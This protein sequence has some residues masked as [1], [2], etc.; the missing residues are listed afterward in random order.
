MVVLPL[1]AL[2]VVAAVAVGAARLAYRP[3]PTEL[4]AAAP[5]VRPAEGSVPAS[6]PE[7]VP[8][9]V[10][11]A[12][13]NGELPAVPVPAGWQTFEYD[14]LRLSVP[15]AW[16]V[17]RHS[18]PDEQGC[19]DPTT[20][21][22]DLNW[23]G[24]CEAAPLT[25]F[26]MPLECGD[27]ECSRLGRTGLEVLGVEML[28]G[29]QVVRV[30]TPCD[31]CVDLVVPDLDVYLAFA[32]VS[33]VEWETVLSTLDRSTRWR[34]LHE[35][36]M[37]DTTGWQAV[38]AGGV[39]DVPLMVPGSWSVRRTGGAPPPPDWPW[40]CRDGFGSADAGRVYVDEGLR[41]KRQ[42]CPG[43]HAG[44]GVPVDAVVVRRARTD[45]HESDGSGADIIPDLLP[46]SATNVDGRTIVTFPSFAA[47]AL[48]IEVR[49][50]SAAQPPILVSIGVGTDPSVT[51]TILHSLGWRP[52]R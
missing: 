6:V 21:I 23:P 48:T 28:N 30:E 7:P 44:M 20:R 12:D 31:R 32:K 27:R 1:A 36:P 9:P 33:D 43:H 49:I 11:A 37:V 18:I 26:R 38:D 13:P 3:V 46:G 16:V 34:A 17:L 5:T 51:R 50:E 47:G 15:P 29:L 42:N 41:S 8:E 19:P 2:A 14:D 35:G 39:G 22:V 45:E 24:D 4:Q 25:V 10:P 52:S 40:I